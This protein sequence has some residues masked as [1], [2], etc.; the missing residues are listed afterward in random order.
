M[1]DRVFNLC[2]HGI[3]QPPR[4]LSPGEAEYW[5][6]ADRFYAILDALRGRDDIRLSV[7]DGNASDAQIAL[8]ALLE[9][10]LVA[11][12]FLV[13]DRLGR[14]GFIDRE[15]VSSL[16][17]NGF[18]VGC[19]GM[20]H[21]PWRGLGADELS[22]ELVEAREVLAEAAGTQVRH[23]AFPFGAYDRR[24]LAA[25]RRAGYERA[26][27]AD[28]GSAE[29]DAWLQTRVLV[30][31]DDD[32]ELVGKLAPGTRNGAIRRAKMLVKRWR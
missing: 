26:F 21:R 18:S 29:P 13:A 11:T 16:V 19:H 20:A 14:A 4:E 12:F 7:D 31:R 6:D 23:A 32:A 24:V 27:T 28:S 9:R 17:A 2:F 15:G 5:L 22:V 10:N 1:P 3:G 25:V 8:P 30:R